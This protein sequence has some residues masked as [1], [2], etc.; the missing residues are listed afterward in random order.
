MK[1]MSIGVSSSCLYPM[2]PCDSLE[3]L[4]R[5]GVKVCEVFI[6]S[7]SELTVSYAQKLN[8]IKNEYGMD[9]LSLHPFTSFAE[10]TMLFSEY[11]QRFFDMLEYYKTGFETAA[12]LGAEIFVIHGSKLPAKITN[13]EYFERFATMIEEG[14]KFGITVTPENVNNHLSEN[15]EF[16][17]AMR[18]YLGNEFKMVFDV[19]QANRA[20]FNPL[21]FAEE[22]AENIIHVHLSDHKEGFDCLPP[23]K[24]T[25]DFA[26]LFE[27]MKNADYKGNY[28]VELYRHNYSEPAE[29]A[30]AMH[31][32]EGLMK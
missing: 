14:K 10:T 9:I 12:T 11:K 22:F 25:F 23:S 3:I 27:I 19:K 7:P 31:Y 16:M 24:G 1:A 15:P 6:N 13:E 20:G 4:G 30:Q 2:P 8:K 17:K 28:V 26:K 5:L 18:A 32:L 29:L 21:A